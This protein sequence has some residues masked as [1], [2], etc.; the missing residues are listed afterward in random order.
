MIFLRSTLLSTVTLFSVFTNALHTL[1]TCRS[2]DSV[3][4]GSGAREC[5]HHVHSFSSLNSDEDGPFASIH[6]ASGDSISNN[7]VLCYPGTHS[8]RC[9]STHCSTELH[10]I[11]RVRVPWLDLNCVSKRIHVVAHCKSMDMD[12]GAATPR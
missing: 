9:E 3:Y 1:A 2:I 11:L 5:S 6:P 12:V 8:G 10:R 4:P 7:E